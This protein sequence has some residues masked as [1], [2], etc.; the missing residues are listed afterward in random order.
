[1]IS[2]RSRL[3]DNLAAVRNVTTQPQRV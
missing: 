1:L 3:R 2:V